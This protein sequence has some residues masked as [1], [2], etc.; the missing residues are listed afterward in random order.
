MNYI[1]HPCLLLNGE[2]FV[3]CVYCTRE[4]VPGGSPGGQ[5]GLGGGKALQNK[6]IFSKPSTELFW[7][8]DEIC[9]LSVYKK[10]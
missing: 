8:L 7:E 9:N 1:M 2:I 10:N 3:L 6:G 4:E 5:V